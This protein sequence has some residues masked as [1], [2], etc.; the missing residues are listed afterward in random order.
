MLAPL[1]DQRRAATLA[2]LVSGL[3]HTL[4]VLHV[5]G[6]V[7][8][9]LLEFLVEVGKS[10]RPSFLALFNFVQFFFEP[11]GVLDIENIREVFHQQIG[12]N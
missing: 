2:F 11:C 5:L 1:D 9:V 4:D 7:F 12:H 10:L 8:E 3:L 6:G